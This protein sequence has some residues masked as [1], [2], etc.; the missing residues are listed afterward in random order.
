[1]NGSQTQA[2]SAFPADLFAGR[3]V[4]V[5]GGSSGIGAGVAAGFLRHG[6]AVTVTGAT[7]QDVAGTRQR[8]TR[9]WAP[10]RAWTCWSTA[11][12]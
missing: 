3:H 11:R 9:W 12:A 6:A 4:L 1:M 2:R 7:E 10:C 8:W 5:V